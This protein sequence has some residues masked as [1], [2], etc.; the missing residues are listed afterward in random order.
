MAHNIKIRDLNPAFGAEISGFDP[1]APL[2]AETCRVL[3]DAFDRRSL[4]VFRDIDIDQ[5]S[6]AR[7]C[8]MLIGKNEAS[9]EAGGE[10]IPED[11]YYVSNKR[12]AA[13]A[14]YGRLRFHSDAMWWHLPYEVLSLYGADV[15]QPSVPTVFVSARQAWATLPAALRAKVQGLSATHT[16]AQLSRNTE[17]GD[18][19]VS[20]IKS[21]PSTTRPIGWRHPRTGDTVLW[22]CEQMTEKVVGLPPDESEALL[23]E[24]FT[25]LY[26]PAHRLEHHWH[27][28]DLVIWDNIALQHARP[29]VKINGPARTLRKVAFPHPVLTPDQMPSH[30][31]AMA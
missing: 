10:A 14:P 28:R 27:T 2:D 16:A 3:R 20:L 30:K 26:A 1:K 21:P 31:A 13:A 18:V 15:E 6:H 5:P 9:A 22:A 12:P 29:E 11:R 19:L 23:Q 17:D 4:L 8:L 25:H 24:L 7:L